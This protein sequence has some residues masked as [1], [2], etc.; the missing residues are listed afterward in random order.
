M[1][2]K[3]ITPLLYV[4]EIEPVLAFWTAKLGFAVT[5]EIPE[6]DALGFVMLARDDV[7]VMYQTRAS[8]ESD[9]PSMADTPMGGTVLFV[10]VDDLDA[11]ETALEGVDLVVPRRTTFYGSQ[12]VWVREPAGNLV[13]FAQF[14]EG[15]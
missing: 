3:K 8:V 10:E 7:E 15:G 5:T 6:G 4:D 11:I 12:E 9:L 14:A 13:G 1:R 2:V